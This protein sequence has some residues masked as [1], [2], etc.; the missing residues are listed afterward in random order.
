MNL[1]LFEVIYKKGDK[2]PADFL[3][4]NAVDAINFDLS[5]YAREQNKDDILQ[6]LQLYLL[7]KV[8][9]E[10]NQLAQLIYKMS[11]DCFVLDGVIWKRLGANQQHRSVLLVPQHL[12]PEILHEAHGHLLA[13]HFGVTKTKQGLLQS[14]YWPIMER[15]ITEH[16]RRCDKC[17]LTKKGKM[18]QKLLS[19]L[20]QCTEPNQQVNA[21]LFGPLKTSEGDKKFI[22]CITEAFTKYVKLVVLPN[23]EALTVATGILNHWI[24]HFG[25]PL[26]LITDQG[27]EFTNKMAEHL[28]S[29]LN[30]RQ[31][32]TSSYHPHCNSQAKV[33]NKT[34]AKYL[35][36]FV[37]ESTLDWEIYVPALMFAYN[38]SYH[39]SIKATPFSLTYG[40]EAWLPSC[41]V[42]DLCRLHDP[43]NQEGDLTTRLNAAC[44][45]SVAHNLAATDQQKEYFNK[46]ATHH[47]FHEGQ[48]VLLDDFNFL[49]K[50]CKLA[51]KFSGP[52]KIL[53]VKSP[54]N[55]ELLLAKGHKIVVNVARI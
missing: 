41:F 31:S 43:T 51:P 28:F 17:Q 10:N 14:Y 39:R 18:A 47:N 24:F 22:L 21:D 8:L 52:F 30:I 26:K 33:S 27:K 48:F 29:S 5:T 12:I 2:M 54:H 49:N 6:N 45:L 16:L 34:I 53:R 3:S 11:Q 25:L 4:R 50:N 20:L 23:K 1:F 42:P 44:E 15:D 32:T 46:K 13:G 9:P 36:A 35:A 7:N 40:L 37:D 55:V 19:P 38:T